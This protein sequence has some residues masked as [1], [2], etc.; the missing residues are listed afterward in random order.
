[1]TLN[2]SQELISE[3]DAKLAEIQSR[4]KE[5]HQLEWVNGL[6]VWRLALQDIRDL[7]ALKS[8]AARSARALGGMESIGEIA[9][10]SHDPRLMSFVEELYAICQQIATA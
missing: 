7:A 4:L 2:I 5:H 9:T 1:M 10:T 6:E 3:Y 8:H